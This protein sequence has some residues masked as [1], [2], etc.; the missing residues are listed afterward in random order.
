MGIFKK[1]TVNVL[2]PSIERVMHEEFIHKNLYDRLIKI[3]L[4]KKIIGEAKIIGHE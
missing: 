2:F 3:C 1:Y 4:G